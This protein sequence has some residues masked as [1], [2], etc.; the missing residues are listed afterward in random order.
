MSVQKRILVINS[1]Y[2]PH[3]GGGAEIISKIQVEG[4]QAHGFHVAVLA[5]GPDQGLHEE[6]IDN[7]KVYRAGLKNLYWHFNDRKPG[8]LIRLGWHLNDRYNSG[9]RKHVREVIERERPDVVICHNL[10][11]WSISAWDE[12][13]SK[14]IPIIQ[15]LHDLYLACSNFTMFKNGHAC[16]KQCATCKVLRSKHSI[17]SNKVTAVV[18]VSNFIL[19]KL[20][21]MG[22][23]A[24]SAK[25]AIHNAREIPDTGLK[26]PV[27]GK[28]P[29][30]FGY[31]GTLAAVKGVEWL[32][33]EFQALDIDATLTIAGKGKD[34]YEAHL[35][36]IAHSD[37]IKFIGYANSKDFYTSIDVSVIPS[38]WPDTFPGVA[39]EA[40][41]YHVPAIATKIGGLP[42]II[43]DG[44]NGI[45][46]DPTDRTSLKEAIMLMYN[47]AQLR[48]KLAHNARKTVENLLSV[49]RMI[50]DYKKVIESTLT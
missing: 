25:Y 18:G 37:K 1:L 50:N 40:S 24:K 8:K 42:E 17:A 36:S 28:Q 35:K 23:F 48:N 3:I 11:G 34:D 39:F 46:C 5:T 32:I 45:L 26:E 19:N 31:I 30:K 20:T 22:Y 4:L 14:N 29:L 27:T 13:S 44:E 21:G 6:V 33:E 12:I 7:V 43:K 2:S 15:V 49:D 41:A 10:A 16:E 38:L 47:N 9:M